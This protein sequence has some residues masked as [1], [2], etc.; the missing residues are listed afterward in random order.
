M[1][2]LQ[3]SSIELDTRA[4]NFSFSSLCKV[5]AILASLIFIAFLL[6]N[7]QYILAL[8]VAILSMATMFCYRLYQEVN[9]ID[10]SID[11]VELSLEEIIEE[12]G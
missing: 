11:G 3:L 1:K 7:S 5:M 10:F 2:I 6:F 9:Q 12:L 4:I 8:V